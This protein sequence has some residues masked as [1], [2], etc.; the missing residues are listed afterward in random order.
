MRVNSVLARRY[1]VGDSFEQRSHYGQS[2]KEQTLSKICKNKDKPINTK[3]YLTQRKSKERQEFNGGYFQLTIVYQSE[4]YLQE[5]MSSERQ[6]LSDCCREG[7]SRI[8][9]GKRKIDYG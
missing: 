1:G 3:P 4:F 8:A 2:E 9:G 5:E 7:S 6:K